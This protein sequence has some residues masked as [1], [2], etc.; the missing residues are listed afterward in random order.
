MGDPK[1]SAKQHHRY[2]NTRA[3]GAMSERVNIV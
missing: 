3:P 1:E 2:G